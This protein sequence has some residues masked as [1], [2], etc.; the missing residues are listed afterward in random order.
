MA[1]DRLAN[2]TGRAMAKA[3]GAPDFPIALVRAEDAPAE[4][5]DSDEQIES[6]ARHLAVQVE[7]IALG[8]KLLR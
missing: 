4:T 8:R 7:A 5:P 2:T 6:M 3:L 1:V